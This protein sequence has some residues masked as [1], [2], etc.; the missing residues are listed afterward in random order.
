MVVAELLEGEGGDEFFERLQQSSMIEIKCPLDDCK[1]RL[2]FRIVRVPAA[3]ACAVSTRF[4]ELCKQSYGGM[5]FDAS[6]VFNYPHEEFEICSRGNYID[7]LLVF[8]KWLYTS[9]IYHDNKV[10]PFE[11]WKFAEVIGA[12][13]FQN[14]ALRLLSQPDPFS[15]EDGLLIGDFEAEFIKD[16]CDAVWRNQDIA[17]EKEDIGLLDTDQ[18]QE[19][20]DEV[21]KKS[22]R[23]LFAF[24]CAAYIGVKDAEVSY[25]L[26]KGG[27]FAVCLARRLVRMTKRKYRKHPPW[28]LTNIKK[29]LVDE[30]LPDDDG[31][32][33][34]D[35][36]ESI[37][38]GIIKAVIKAEEDEAMH[39]DQFL[40]E[41]LFEKSEEGE[42]DQLMDEDSQ[43]ETM[44][45]ESD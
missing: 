13:K 10:S 35:D 18:I 26:S 23:L 33:D 37:V 6:D 14:A 45:E 25:Q 3:L 34:E 17:D 20:V 15:P 30:N 31:G 8:V 27:L 38:S 9:K 2:G 43:S 32:D 21:D 12:P 7:F 11:I 16:S 44:G 19:L 39:E 36:D 42:E 28:H 1:P 24:D 5:R 41:V 29:Y 22:K 4:R 40:P